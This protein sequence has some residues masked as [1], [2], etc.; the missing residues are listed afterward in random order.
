M[1]MAMAISER[2]P[3]VSVNIEYYCNG[4]GIGGTTG[5]NNGA[6]WSLGYGFPSSCMCMEF[7]V[8]LISAF[9]WKRSGEKNSVGS[10]GGRAFSRRRW[11]ENAWEGG[12]AHD[13]RRT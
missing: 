1:A 5:N 4:G 10:V 3:L 9:S 8:C 2:L 13:R 11:V 6:S 12:G 7:L